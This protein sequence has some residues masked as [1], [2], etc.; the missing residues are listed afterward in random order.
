M[1]SESCRTVVQY[2]K[3]AGQA[4]A[5]IQASRVELGQMGD[6]RRRGLA[7]ASGEASELYRERVIIETIESGDRHGL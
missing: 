5:F 4:F 6:E 1:L 3:T 7:L 2:L